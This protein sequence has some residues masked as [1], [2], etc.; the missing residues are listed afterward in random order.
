LP[1]PAVPGAPRAVLT[2]PRAVLAA[3]R[4][5]LLDLDGTLLDTAPDLGAAMNAA[6][7]DSGFAAIAEQSARDF[8]G[9]GI[10]NLVRRSLELSLGSA[11][12]PG[13]F[14][15]VLARFEVHYARL[16]GSASRHYPGALEG[17]AAMRAAGLPLACVTNKAARFTRPLLEAT[18]L[19]GFF[20]AVITPEEAGARKPDPAPYRVACRALGVAPAE[21]VAI[22]DSL[23]D[24]QSARAAGCR[25]LLVP[26]GY[27]EGRA[28]HEVPADGIVAT[29]ID[30][31][32]WCSE[33][34]SS[35][36]FP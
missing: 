5:V 35:K 30:A 7:A 24:S 20:A 18:G 8:I 22:G 25:F 4:A 31:A 21:A 9:R 26:Y 17:L 3:P 11:A 28:L 2:A 15:A 33:P 10:A 36:T 1:T 23:N 6:L 34:T 29:L 27:R 19:A 32:A 14:D 12:E 13:V 16:N